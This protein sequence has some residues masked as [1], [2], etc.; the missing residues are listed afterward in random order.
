[1]HHSL[2]FCTP[3]KFA[4]GFTPDVTHLMEFDSWETILRLDE[5]TQFPES[6]EIFCWYDVSTSNE[7]DLVCSWF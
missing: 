1:M 6:R 7:G 3:H 4:H 2:Y 5:K